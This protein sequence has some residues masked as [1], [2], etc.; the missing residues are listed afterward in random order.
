MPYKTLFL[1]LIMCIFVGFPVQAQDQET[2][3]VFK[4]LRS[5]SATEDLDLED[6]DEDA[7]WEPTIKPGQ[8][9][10]SFMLGSLNL[11]QVL[12]AH[13]TIIYKYTDEN[14]YWGNVAFKGAASAFSPSLRMSYS[15]NNIFSLEGIGNFTTCDYSTNITNRV[16]RTN[17]DT[18]VVS[19]QEP[20]LEEFDGERRSMVVFLGSINAVVYPMNIRGD[21]VSRWQ[22]YLTGGTGKVWY[23]MNSDYIEGT[24]SS[25]NLCFGAGL[26]F[27]AE[28]TVSVRME[29]VFLKHD[30]EWSP[31]PYFQ[32]LNE[33]TKIIDLNEY[34]EG[35]TDPNIVTS[36]EP[37]SIST[38][39]ISLG[40]QASF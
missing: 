31:S 36:Y 19:D 9:E 7:Y 14:T 10:L 1:L 2:E 38:T 40:F 22:P 13:D 23:N 21:R 39:Q 5:S 16:I 15:I 25:S 8:F 12:L 3:K 29:V 4:L 32:S 6:E 20:D 17:G 27:L 18:P 37:N 11:D 26:R 24:T 30:L 34:S 28:K 33:G 35:P